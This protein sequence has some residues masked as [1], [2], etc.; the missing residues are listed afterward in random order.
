MATKA[1]TLSEPIKLGD[2]TITEVVVRSPKVREVRA[3]DAMSKAGGADL[4][5]AVGAILLL[6]DLTPEAAEELD[7][8]DM[9]TLSE[10]IASFFE[11]APGRANGGA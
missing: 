3:L 9:A 11:A 1:I 2:R 6:T 8:V 5:E 10:A 7:T 4:D